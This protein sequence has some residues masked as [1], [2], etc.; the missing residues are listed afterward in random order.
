MRDNDGEFRPR[1]A[2]VAYVGE[3]VMVKGEIS[4]PDMIVVDG[5][6]EGTLTARAIMVGPSGSIK[7]NITA[8]EADVQGSVSEKIEIKQLLIVRSTGRV[9]GNISYG[10][11][12]IE[13]GA[14]ISGGFVSTDF[15]SDKRS[16][17][18]ENVVNKLDR[19]KLTKNIEAVE[20][21]LAAKV[22]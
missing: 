7:G 11:I 6:V 21:P 12:E 4:V 19:P 16:P 8:T 20:M 17:K 2:N 14:V 18:V 3:G 13:K 15:R 9:D 5:A 10:E 22:I 1:E